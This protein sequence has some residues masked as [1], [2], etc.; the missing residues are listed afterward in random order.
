MASLSF[1]NNILISRWQK[2][3]AGFPRREHG[4]MP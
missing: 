2:T 4:R 1:Y 3:K